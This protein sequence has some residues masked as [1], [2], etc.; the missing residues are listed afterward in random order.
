MPVPQCPFIEVPGFGTAHINHGVVKP[1][2]KKNKQVKREDVQR[3]AVKKI[4]FN[5]QCHC[6]QAI[7]N[8]SVEDDTDKISQ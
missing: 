6:T 4:C 5:T 2:T 7:E 8:I 1:C 3:Y